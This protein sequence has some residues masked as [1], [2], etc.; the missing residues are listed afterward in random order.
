[1][2]EN[3]QG[4][5]GAR[6]RSETGMCLTSC[7]SM[8]ASVSDGL[9]G[10]PFL[11]TRQVAVVDVSANAAAARG[12]VCLPGQR[13]PTQAVEKWGKRVREGEGGR[14]RRWDKK[15]EPCALQLLGRDPQQT[16]VQ[17]RKSSRAFMT[18]KVRQF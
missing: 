1:M 16:S 3:S 18:V 5:E 8:P 15:I 13:E 6:R 4:E 17:M 7:R 2:L 11:T 14:K 12:A 10:F 9:P